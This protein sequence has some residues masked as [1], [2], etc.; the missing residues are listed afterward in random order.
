MSFI[1][2]NS[3][4]GISKEGVSGLIRSSEVFVSQCLFY[5]FRLFELGGDIALTG[6]RTCCYCQLF[7]CYDQIRDILLFR[8][9]L[10]GLSLATVVMKKTETCIVGL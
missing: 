9:K 6:K 1:L 7:L 5:C 8:L 2:A 4:G 10:D 3:A